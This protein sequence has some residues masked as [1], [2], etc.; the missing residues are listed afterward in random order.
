MKVRDICDT[1]ELA[2]IAVLVK[3]GGEAVA[4]AYTNLEGGDCDCCKVL[5]DAGDKEVLR[6]VN[7]E[8]MEIL[9]QKEP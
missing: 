9:Y 5:Y 3:N 4:L 7:V 6:V 1:Y 8:T 2:K